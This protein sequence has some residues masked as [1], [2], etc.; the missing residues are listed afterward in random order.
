[1]KKIIS[2]FLTAALLLT[3]TS[4]NREA[5]PPYESESDY[6]DKLPFEGIELAK[7][8]DVNRPQYDNLDEL[9]EDSDLIV[10]GT[11]MGDAEQ[12]DIYQYDG[13]FDTD[14]LVM[15]NSTCQVKITQV[16]KG[17]V[18]VGDTIP[19]MQQYGVDKEKNRLLTYSDLTPMLDGDTWL[20][21]LYD[22]RGENYMCCGDRHGRYPVENHTYRKTALTDSEELGVFNEYNFNQEIYDEILEKYEF[23]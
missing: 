17:D 8:G 18:K 16:F 15:T 3:L 14:I 7:A 13:H 22:N 9:E 10:V 21:F 11:C 5:E 23:E 4:C 20:F 12:K 6:E 2:L 1:M 19:V